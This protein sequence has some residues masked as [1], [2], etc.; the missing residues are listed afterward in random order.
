MAGPSVCTSKCCVSASL[1]RSVRFAKEIVI[2]KGRSVAQAVVDR[3]AEL[4]GILFVLQ[5]GSRGQ[6]ASVCTIEFDPVRKSN[7]FLRTP[8]KHH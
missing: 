8:A 7:A 4:T 5:S 6:A 3:N 1:S 2:A